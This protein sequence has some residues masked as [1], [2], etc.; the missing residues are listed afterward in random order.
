MIC[1][2]CGNGCNFVVKCVQYD[3]DF[4]EDSVHEQVYV[5]ISCIRQKVQA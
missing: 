4:E 5:C 2:I 1:D 3:G